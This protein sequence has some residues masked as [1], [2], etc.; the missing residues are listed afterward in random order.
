MSVLSGP[1]LAAYRVDRLAKLGRENEHLRA[2]QLRLIRLL[3]R[4]LEV[5]VGKTNVTVPALMGVLCELE[6]TNPSRPAFV[7]HREHMEQE[8]RVDRLVKVLRETAP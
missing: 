6:G 8:A 7:E 2:E 4:A 1:W 5:A 3:G